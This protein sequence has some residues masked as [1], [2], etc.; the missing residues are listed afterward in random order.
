MGY[1]YSNTGALCCDKC[2]TSGGVRKRKCTYKVLGNSLRGNRI[3]MHYCY[4]PALC[5]P[6]LK[7]LGGQ[8]VLH[9]DCKEPAARSQA[10]ADAIE[11][12]L[13]AGEA[14]AIAA[15]GSAYDHVPPGQVG[16]KYRSRTGECYVLIAA[17][18]YARYPRPVLSAVHTTPWCGPNGQAQA[19]DPPR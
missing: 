19:A 6:C 1:S 10:E 2:G 13:D 14:F 3:S 18:D 8:T 12:Q 15:W 11:R 4:P 7:A 17:A 9:K 5:I 16:V